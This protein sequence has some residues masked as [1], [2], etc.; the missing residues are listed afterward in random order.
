MQMIVGIVTREQPRGMARVPQNLVE[1]D[2]SIKLSAGADTGVDLL[3]HHFF[4]GGI[5]AER[6]RSEGRVLERWDR[7]P[8]DS[9]CLSMGARYELTIAGYY[10]LGTHTLG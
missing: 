6:G 2:H 1:I 5:K 3:T 8:N 4:L 9:N 10:V 7:G